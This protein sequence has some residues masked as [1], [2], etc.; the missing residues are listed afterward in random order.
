MKLLMNMQ[1]N[2]HPSVSLNIYYNLNP[3]EILHMHKIVS[4]AITNKQYLE[5]DLYKEA[6]SSSLI[7]EKM[8]HEV[9]VKIKA[10]AGDEK[11][12]GVTNE[13]PPLSENIFLTETDDKELTLKDA[14]DA[15][16]SDDVLLS[17]LDEESLIIEDDLT[18]DSI[19]NI[20]ATSS[21]LIDDFVET[22]R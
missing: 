9:D 6:Q 19:Q 15:N 22:D 5:Q 7:I 16:K 10:H 11:M 8:E 17:L 20:N 13:A 2:N 18:V 4:N 14:I 12:V 21:I 3:T 1:K